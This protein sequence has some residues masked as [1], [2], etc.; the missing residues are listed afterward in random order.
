MEIKLTSRPKNP[1]I[2]SGY[3]GFGMVGMIATEFLIEHLKTESI[4]KIVIP[5]LPALVAIHEKDLLVGGRGGGGGGGGFPQS[6]IPDHVQE[7]PPSFAC[8]HSPEFNV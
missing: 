6:S 8:P 7:Q 3:P 5:E 2:I 1:T 4:G